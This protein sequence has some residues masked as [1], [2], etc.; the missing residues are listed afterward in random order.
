M[1]AAVLARVRRGI[2]A[3][4]LGAFVLPSCVLACLACEERGGKTSSSKASSSRVASCRVRLREG[5]SCAEGRGISDDSLERR[6]SDQVKSNSLL[7]RFMER[8]R[9]YRWL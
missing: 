3:F 5:F 7:A 9:T 4:V 1:E 2:D 6:K 8:N